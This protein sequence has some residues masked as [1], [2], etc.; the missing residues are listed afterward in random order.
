MQW[1]ENYNSYIFNAWNEKAKPIDTLTTS[2]KE[3]VKD[4]VD[5]DDEIPF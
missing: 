5:V 1:I 3:I 2:D 4:L